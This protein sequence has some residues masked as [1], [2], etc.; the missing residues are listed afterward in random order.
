MYV[1]VYKDKNVI[2]NYRITDTFCFTNLIILSLQQMHRSAF[3]GGV[4]CYCTWESSEIKFWQV[5]TVKANV[6]AGFQ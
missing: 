2:F 5:A 3:L 4:L 1:H 6:M